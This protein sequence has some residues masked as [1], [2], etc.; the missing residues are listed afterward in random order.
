[1]TFVVQ[2]SNAL[3]F[4]TVAQPQVA[5]VICFSFGT[6]VC[7]GSSV[8]RPPAPF[9]EIDSPAH[10]NLEYLKDDEEGKAEVHSHEAANVAE[11][12]CIL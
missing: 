11:R 4:H 3:W 5:E 2:L 12:G 8:G 6:L 9:P 1:M 7:D 10:K